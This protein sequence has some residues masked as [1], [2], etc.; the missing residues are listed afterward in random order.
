MLF[1]GSEELFGGICSHV[2]VLDIHIGALVDGEILY[3]QVVEVNLAQDG[4]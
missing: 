1:G 4:M 3:A 2:A